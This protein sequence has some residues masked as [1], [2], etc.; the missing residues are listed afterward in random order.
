MQNP[1]W[2]V[3]REG[4]FKERNQRKERKRETAAAAVLG[5]RPSR[6]P[7]PDADVPSSAAFRTAAVADSPASVIFKRRRKGKERK[8]AMSRRQF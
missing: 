4:S 3:H 7:L 1:R 5:P 2:E 8:M 6:P